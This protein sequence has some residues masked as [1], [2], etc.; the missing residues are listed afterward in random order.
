MEKRGCDVESRCAT[1]TDVWEQS[2]WWQLNNITQRGQITV[3]LIQ[4]ELKK[5]NPLVSLLAQMSGF[6]LICL[7]CAD[8]KLQAV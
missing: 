6:S 4:K 5:K 3:G 2:L 8:S 1:A 7:L